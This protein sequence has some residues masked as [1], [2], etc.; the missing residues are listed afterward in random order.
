MKFLICKL[1]YTPTRVARRKPLDIKFLG[2]SVGRACLCILLGIGPNRLRKTSDMIPDLR[3]GKTKSG[4]R[5]QTHSVDAFL[6][7]LYEGVAETLP[8]RPGVVQI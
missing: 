3:V 1:S 2:K 4:S 5:E 8:D 7:M 6:S